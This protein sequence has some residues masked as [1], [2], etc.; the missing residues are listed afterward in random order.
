M[1]VV[2][3]AVAVTAVLLSGCTVVP[4]KTTYQTCQLLD[5]AIKESN[6]LSPGWYIEAGSILEK[7]GDPT[8]PARAEF[9]AC[10]AD[11]NQTS[12]KCFEEK[13]KR[14]PE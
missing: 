13:N 8:G 14:I 11:K 1:K 3:I 9:T 10:F 2:K 6:E 5:I 12:E 7:C 4:Y